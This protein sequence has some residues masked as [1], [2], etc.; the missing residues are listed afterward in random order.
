MLTSKVHLGSRAL[1]QP[2]HRHLH[3]QHPR[4]VPPC[5]RASATAAAVPLASCTAA[6]VNQPS[7]LQHPYSRPIADAGPTHRWSAEGGAPLSA[8]S[9]RC[10][11]SGCPAATPGCSPN[12]AGS[13]W[14]RTGA[15]LQSSMQ[16]GATAVAAR[17]TAPS[18]AR[19]RWLG[20]CLGASISACL[21]AQAS[22]EASKAAVIIVLLG[23]V[24]VPEGD[25]HFAAR[26]LQHAAT[27]AG[28]VRCGQQKRGSGSSSQSQGDRGSNRLRK[29]EVQA[30]TTA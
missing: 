1:D 6:P 13:A 12:P 30:P 21:G 28:R 24:G 22:L 26:E 20:K 29:W 25:Q 27:A 2:L 14:D 9:L 5:G 10:C 3:L 4:R 18:S 17:N 11:G 15:R 8:S 23:W 19:R 7:L 16:P